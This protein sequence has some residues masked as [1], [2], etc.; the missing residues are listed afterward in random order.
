MPLSMAT[1]IEAQYKRSRL[2]KKYQEYDQDIVSQRKNRPRLQLSD[3]NLLR[4][5][6]TGSFGRVHL[7]Q[8]RH[9]A[10]YYAIKVLKKTEVVRLKQGINDKWRI[11]LWKL[12]MGIIVEHT[13]NEK[14]ILEG[15]ANPF[16]VN[17][18]G[19]FQDDSNL[20]MVMDYVP[21]G[22]LFSVL[23]KSKV[24]CNYNVLPTQYTKMIALCITYQRFPDHV[25]KFYAA[26]VILALEY[27]HSRRIV[28][29]DLKPENLLLDSNGHIRITDFGFAKLIPD[30]VTW[31]LCGTPDY[32]GMLILYMR[33]TKIKGC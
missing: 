12:K 31:T 10:R 8:S 25:A 28:Y 22:E 29:R 5:L 19:T 23:R 17:L 13:N 30:N 27:L 2:Q 16:L 32:L 9:N 4:T 14:H 18:W 7:A 3:F 11:R 6:G 20:Y 15:V 1:Y 24:R 26:E 33:R 21:G